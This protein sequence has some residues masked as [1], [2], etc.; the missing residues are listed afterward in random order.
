MILSIYQRATIQ[1]LLTI[2][3]HASKPQNYRC[4]QF[5]FTWA[6]KSTSVEAGASSSEAYCHHRPKYHQQQPEMCVKMLQ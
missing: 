5:S 3:Q 2:H 1:Q 6:Q 4:E